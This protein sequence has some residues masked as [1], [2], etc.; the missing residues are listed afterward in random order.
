MHNPD[1]EQPQISI[2]LSLL[3]FSSILAKGFPFTPV[4]RIS[5]SQQDV[6]DEVEAKVV[7]SGIPLIA[8]QF[9]AHEQWND[10]LFSF[11]FLSNKHGNDD[12]VCRDLKRCSDVKLTVSQYIA[13]AHS[14][15]AKNGHKDILL[16]ANDLSCPPDWRSL[17]M[18]KILPTFLT[19]MGEND[20]NG[21]S[22]ELAAENLMAYIGQNGT[23]TPAH[24]DHC[25]AIGHNIMVCDDDGSSVWFMVS[26]KD[27]NKFEELCRSLGRE[28]QYENSFLSVDDLS[29]AIFPIYVAEQKTGDLILIPSLS[30]HQVVNLELLFLFKD[31]V[32]DDWI[33]LARL[34]EE[35]WTNLDLKSYEFHSPEK[36]DS[37]APIVCDFCKATTMRFM[38]SFSMASL[39]M[40]YPSAIHAWNTS[41]VIKGCE[42][43]REIDDDWSE[44]K[45]NFNTNHYIGLRVIIARKRKTYF[46]WS[47]VQTPR[48]GL[49]IGDLQRQAP[50][51]VSSVFVNIAYPITMEYYGLTS[52]PILELRSS[53]RDAKITAP[54]PSAR[55]QTTTTSTQS[56][57]QTLHA[58]LP[59]LP[60]PLLTLVTKEVQET[61]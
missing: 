32:K 47:H 43:Y 33:D 44:S 1:V 38:E 37:N 41:S 14:S 30:Y 61:I 35:K 34:A 27:M 4:C 18:D 11:D 7:H 3:N 21:I 40:L 48:L 9:Q 22:P 58:L 42:K 23:W 17:L 2:D 16:Y 28:P 5:S 29:R 20:L 15:T 31:I 6:F 24:I 25:G 53:V 26:D 36:T 54:A 60:T 52:S 56:D 50:D 45:L 8:D 39:R 19:A 12:I 51:N 55:R 10:K 57:L 46:Y 59:N 49:S 13:T